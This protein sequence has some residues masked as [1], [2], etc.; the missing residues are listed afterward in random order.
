[1][2]QVDPPSTMTVF[3]VSGAD[4]GAAELTESDDYLLARERDER[5]A[6]KN[7]KSGVARSI[8]QELAHAYANLRRRMA[9]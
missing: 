5:S 2:T 8:H 3:N 4:Y 9:Q 1:M 6:A 7:A